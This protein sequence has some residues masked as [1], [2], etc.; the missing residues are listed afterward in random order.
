[1]GGNWAFNKKKEIDVDYGI[2]V[3][4]HCLFCLTI[5]PMRVGDPG[6]VTVL[7]DLWLIGFFSGP[8]ACGQWY[9]LFLLPRGN[10]IPPQLKILLLHR[11][12]SALG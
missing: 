9:L 11:N 12:E 7:N 8:Q 4:G 10:S 6:M 3:W 5:D 2:V 1:M